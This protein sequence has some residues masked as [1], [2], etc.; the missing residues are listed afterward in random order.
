MDIILPSEGSGAGSIPAESATLASASEH[1]HWLLALEVC[2]LDSL[3]TASSINQ[4]QCLRASPARAVTSL[5]SGHEAIVETLSLIAID[6]PAMLAP[7]GK[8]IAEAF[9]EVFAGEPW[10]EEYSEEKALQIV[11]AAPTERGAAMMVATNPQGA[12]VAFYWCRVEDPCDIEPR[13]QDAVSKC[14]GGRLPRRYVMSS[15]AGVLPDYRGRKLS[16]RLFLK[17]LTSVCVKDATIEA[18]L[19]KT[20]PHSPMYHLRVR[21]GFVEIFREEDTGDVYMLLVPEKLPA[22]LRLGG[23]VEA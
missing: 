14:C 8:R 6:T 7:Y 16:Q 3:A 19:N 1:W 5:P 23:E 2:K 9:Q 4:C 10:N 21:L 15:E 13:L 20:N 12:V 18:V 22:V 11:E 17:T